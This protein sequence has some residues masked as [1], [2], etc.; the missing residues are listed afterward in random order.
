MSGYTRRNCAIIASAFLLAATSYAHA[1]SVPALSDRDAAGLIESWFA[2]SGWTESLRTGTLVVTR[3]APA[4]VGNDF[5]HGRI[6]EVEYRSVLAWAAAGLIRLKVS[7]IASSRPSFAQPIST[8]CAPL[9]IKRIT[10]TPTTAGLALDGRTP[11]MGMR[12]ARFLYARSYTA[13]VSKI[14]DNSELEQ[15]TDTYRI[16]K[17]IVRFHYSGIG[18]MLTRLKLGHVL[19]NQKQILL[20][21]YDPFDKRWNLVTSDAAALGSDFRTQK[22]ADYLLQHGSL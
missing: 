21:K 17:C 9:A 3:E 10:V 6:S 11:V 20:L 8:E 4:C 2:G 16:I 12:D 7:N 1:I 15:N 22:V 14:V 18:R 5:E 13:E 19:E